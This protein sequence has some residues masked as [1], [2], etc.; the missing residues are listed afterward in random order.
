MAERA[1]TVLVVDDEPEIVEILRDYL[2]A[3]GFQVLTATDGRAAL[4]AL[5]GASVD[6]LL[7]DLMMPGA[8][9]FDVCRQIRARSSHAT[10]FS[11]ASGEATGTRAPCGYISGASGKKSSVIPPNPCIS[12]PCGAW[13]TVS[14]A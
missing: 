1:Q 12:S 5:A 11:S 14:R 4:A 13:A 2:E 6:C 9:G 8:S 7:L 10:S 3:D